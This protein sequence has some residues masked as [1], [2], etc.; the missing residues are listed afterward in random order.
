MLTN[1]IDGLS[2]K[3][4]DQWMATLLTPAFVFWAGGLLAWAFH[5]GW[6]EPVKS[7]NA[8]SP[9]GQIVVLIAAVLVVAASAVVVQRFDLLVIRILEGYWPR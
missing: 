7:F 2:S 6:S 4:A 9:A 3:L 1:I 8:L 5:F